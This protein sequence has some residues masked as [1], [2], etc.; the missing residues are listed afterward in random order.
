MAGTPLVLLHGWGMTPRIWNGLR[1]CLSPRIVATPALPGHGGA[2]SPGADLAAWSDAV[3]DGLPPRCVLGGWSLGA[4]IALDLARRYPER[5]DAL[6]LFGATPRFVSAE[7]WDRGLD[8]VTVA[9][10]IDG[11]ASDQ[12]STLR[13]FLGLQSIGESQRRGV[14]HSLGRAVLA[15]DEGHP[16][17][18]ADGL[19]ILATADLRTA[20][21][22]IAQPVQLIHGRNDAVMPVTAARWLAEQLPDA[23]LDI[24]EGCGHAPMVSQPEVCASLIE[25]CLRG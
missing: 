4:M 10:F 23:R 14:V 11:F 8:T 15:P 17:G 9:G 18:L 13:R 21:P 1:I 22:D 24:M 2:D 12:T 3:L 19:K 5:I 7:D 25:E 20:V 6:V 16:A